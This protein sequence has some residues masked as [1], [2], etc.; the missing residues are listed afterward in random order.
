MENR[1]NYIGGSDIP[2]ICNIGPITPM[3]KYMEKKGDLKVKKNIKIEIGHLLE[4]VITGLYITQFRE[5][6]SDKHNVSMNEWEDGW[7]FQ[8]V[9]AT[10]GLYEF[11]KCHLDGYNYQTKTALEAKS[12][13]KFVDVLP[14]QYL[15]QTA[16][17]C[18]LSNASE[19]HIAVLSQTNTFNL[20]KYERNEKLEKMIID[21]AC[22]FWYQLQT[23]TPPH[24]TSEED[25]KRFNQLLYG[26][27][28]QEPYQATKEVIE[29]LEAFKEVK[30]REKILSKELDEKKSHLVNLIGEYEEVIDEHQNTLLTYRYNASPT[31]RVDTYKLK[32]EFPEIYEQVLKVGSRIRSLRIK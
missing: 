14:P 1:Q 2:A 13:S 9:E 21:K 20:F 11:L 28:H 25:I 29:A 5:K 27:T 15:L 12:T 7:V 18:A 26:N 4:P 30:E 17:N 16:Y 22:N 31:C 10:H 6:E 19:G 32:S 23:N 3:Q 8:D 24:V